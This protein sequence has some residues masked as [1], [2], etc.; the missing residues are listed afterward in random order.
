MD[1]L[2]PKIDHA[3]EVHWLVIAFLGYTSPQT[4][5]DNTNTINPILHQLSH[6]IIKTAL[7][8]D[9]DMVGSDKHG[10]APS[11]RGGLG[12]PSPNG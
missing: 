1:Y 5:A 10:S 8:T 7:P 6:W 11:F 12:L 2:N 4:L 3:W 9:T